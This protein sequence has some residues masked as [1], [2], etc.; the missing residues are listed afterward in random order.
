MAMWKMPNET[1]KGFNELAERYN[2]GIEQFADVALAI[3]RRYL[4]QNPEIKITV[5]PGN[6]TPK[7]Q[8]SEDATNN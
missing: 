4:E 7:I 1:K 8:I 3:V 6:G 2:F 5:L